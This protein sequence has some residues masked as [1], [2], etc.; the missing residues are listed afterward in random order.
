MHK[1]HSEKKINKNNQNILGKEII[2]KL[3][4]LF[5]QSKP[6]IKYSNKINANDILLK[7]IPSLANKINNLQYSKNKTIFTCASKDSLKSTKRQ[8]FSKDTLTI[9]VS[10]KIN[11]SLN[12][13]A[14]FNTLNSSLKYKLKSDNKRIKEIK[15]PNNKTK[16]ENN[17]N[18]PLILNKSSRN[19]KS[20][21]SNN[22]GNIKENQNKIVNNELKPENF[23]NN[24]NYDITNSQSYFLNNF[25]KNEI[26]HVPHVIKDYYSFMF[27]NNKYKERK[28]LFQNSKDFYPFQKELLS[29]SSN[30]RKKECNLNLSKDKSKLFSELRERKTIIVFGKNIPKETKKISK[31][32]IKYKLLNSNALELNKEAKNIFKNG[33]IKNNSI[34]S[35]KESKLIKEEYNINKPNAKYYIP[36]DQFGNIVY[37]IFNQKKIL[38]N[39]LNILL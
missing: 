1:Y 9:D 29:K 31:Q 12:K 28:Q 11:S 2:N 39:I 13:N 15:P 17:N 26:P 21:Y 18:N 4:N 14:K 36:K 5:I 23:K 22:E 24:K 30:L 32:N 16:I 35:L 6:K 38:K 8:S 10:E 19:I 20:N 37:P 33:L 25:E 27:N 34:K 7:T 3:E